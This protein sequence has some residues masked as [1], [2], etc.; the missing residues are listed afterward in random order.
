MSPEG[1]RRNVGH[2]VRGPTEWII[3]ARSRAYGAPFV[4]LTR[5]GSNPFGRHYDPMVR[6]W[7]ATAAAM[8]A[9]RRRSG[10]TLSGPTSRQGGRAPSRRIWTRRG[11]AGRVGR[12][13][14]DAVSMRRRM[15]A[16][17]K[18]RCRRARRCRRG[19][20]CGRS[21]HSRKAS[22]TSASV[23]GS[24]WRAP[25]GCPGHRSWS[26]PRC[27]C[28]ARSRAPARRGGARA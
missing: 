25:R 27:G 22:K 9:R 10:P 3:A 17:G 8:S 7:A 16:A 2:G 26:S 20:A 12:P 6:G 5:A 13:A 15:Y 14:V 11:R 1:P 28:A 24:S 23:P 19:A 18:R 4:T 21:T